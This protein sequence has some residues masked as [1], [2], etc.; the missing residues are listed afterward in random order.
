[1]STHDF[2]RNVYDE[3]GEFLFA[4]CVNCGIRS[5]PELMGRECPGAGKLMTAAMLNFRAVLLTLSIL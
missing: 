4:A 1:M 3:N 2:N 5:A